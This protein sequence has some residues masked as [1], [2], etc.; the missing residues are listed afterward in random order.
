[1][2]TPAENRSVREFDG[3]RPRLRDGLRFSIQEQDGRRVCV[4]EDPAASR[5]HRVGLE[6]Y[7]FLRSLDGTRTVA[8]LLAELARTSGG[9]TWSE[10]DAS[11]MLRWARDQHLA[12]LETGRATPDREHGER[13]LRTAATWLNPLT[14][15][16]PLGRPDRLFARAA[17]LSRPLLGRAGFAAWLAV[18]AAGAAHLGPEWDRFSADTGGLL[19]R[20]NWLWLLLAWTGLKV[21]HECGHGIVCKAFGAPVREAGA[22]F[23]LGVPMGYVD[24][25]ASL[26]LASKW[27]RMGV[28]A[29]GI[30]V[31][32]FLAA[33][34]AII[35]ARTEPGTIHTL[36]HNV[37]VTGT[38]ITLLFNG[39]PLMRFDGYFIL[40][41]ALELPN[42]ATRGRSW[43]QRALASGLL[44][45]GGAPFPRPGGREGW[46][47]AIYGAAAWAWQL[48]VLA[49]LLVGASSLL[50]GGGLPFAALAA[51]AWVALPLGRFVAGL[52][53]SVRS[54]AGSW[55]GLA[56]RLAL[57]AVLG[58][59]V[60]FVPWRRSVSA[61]GVVELADTLPL[62]AECP[63]F[64]ETVLVG[65]GDIVAEG[66]LLVDLRNE[67]AAAR[68]ARARL[69]L[70]E[71]ELRARL[72]YTREDVSTFQAE[73]AKA[74]GQRQTVEQLEKYTA[75]LQLRAPFAG[76]VTNR[77]LAQSQGVFFAPGAEVMR[78]GRADGADV[79]IAVSER[80]AP[81]FRDAIG[82]DVQIRVEGRAGP[83]FPATLA[84]MEGRA[85]REVSQPA[86]TAIAG[87]PLALRR[88]EDADATDNLELAEPH[89]TA[90]ARL[91]GATML[92]PGETARV[93]LR[94]ARAVTLWAEMEGV[95]GRWLG[96]AGAGG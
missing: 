83:S 51:I 86:L 88:S 20:G 72:A 57:L 69:A 29:A 10:Q 43:M 36:A 91:A 39:N 52:A 47:V 58:S 6:E 5:F 61:A 67:E 18:L 33:I 76:R 80:D 31:E 27:R 32:F 15:K 78:L 1:M 12:V 28:A 59:A 8:T 96:Q 30:Y 14:I 85:T 81:H 87:G 55:G 75:T 25:T 90:T 44:G 37:V 93:R 35:W 94:S 2:K 24:A 89:F 63:G 73:Q 54:G 17:A 13:A 41:D 66:Q 26:G 50:R 60:L 74:E 70:G 9:S 49:G 84:R 48:A 40:S 56:V 22:I 11:Q 38:L 53:S 79:K 21:A 19:E 7:L 82:G 3:L 45:S 46:I 65:D 16:L 71:Q 68:L 42:L 34:A 64:V 62:R 95:I 4:I 92:L 23:I 77:N